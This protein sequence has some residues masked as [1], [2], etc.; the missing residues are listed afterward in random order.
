MRIIFDQQF[1][2]V[3]HIIAQ[4]NIFKFKPLSE[5]VVTRKYILLGGVI[6]VWATITT[7]VHHNQP[8]NNLNTHKDRKAHV[9][10]VCTSSLADRICL[11][12]GSD[13]QRTNIVTIC[14][15]MLNYNGLQI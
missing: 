15:S 13:E 10:F 5:I 3:R 14:N 7:T 11:L 12:V 8:P 1:V 9:Q 4:I 6:I 2:L